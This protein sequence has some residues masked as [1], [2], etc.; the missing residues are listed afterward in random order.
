[1][2]PKLSQVGTRSPLLFMIGDLR[3]VLHVYGPSGGTLFVPTMAHASR[4]RVVL[5]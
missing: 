3:D 2:K 5:C 1:M 4:F